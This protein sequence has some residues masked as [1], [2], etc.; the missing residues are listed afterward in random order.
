MFPALLEPRADL[1]FLDSLAPR[2]QAFG[3]YEQRPRIL[4]VPRQFLAK[5][6]FGLGHTPIQEQHGGS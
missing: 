3:Q 5:N 1:R 2:A 4:S 6:T